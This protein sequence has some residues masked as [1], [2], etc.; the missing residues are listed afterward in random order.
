MRGS[1]C[2]ALLPPQAPT[3]GSQEQVFLD[4]FLTASSYGR[5][6]FRLVLAMASSHPPEAVPT[7]PARASSAAVGTRTGFG[8]AAL[9]STRCPDSPTTAAAAAPARQTAK[10]Q[11]APRRSTN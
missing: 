5:T 2:G 8:S 7:R 10:P 3:E 4:A 9:R 1:A 6:P 11:P